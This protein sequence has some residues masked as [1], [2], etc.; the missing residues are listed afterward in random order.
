[1]FFNHSIQALHFKGKEVGV[2][3]KVGACVLI[4]RLELFSQILVLGRPHCAST[5]FRNIHVN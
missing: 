2:Y 3:L 1:M 5:S 4:P